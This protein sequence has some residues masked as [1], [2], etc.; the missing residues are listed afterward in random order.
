MF[1]CLSVALLN[2][3]VKVF[4]MLYYQIDEL[5][6][7]GFIGDPLVTLSSLHFGLAEGFCSQFVHPFS[8]KFNF[9]IPYRGHL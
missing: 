2:I 1:V 8:L 9:K 7:T 3:C 6:L 4:K 5:A